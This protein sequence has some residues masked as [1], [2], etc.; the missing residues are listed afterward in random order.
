MNSILKAEGK[1]LY[2]S[3]TAVFGHL[4]Q[5]GVPSP[6]DRIRATRLAVGCI[7]WIEEV[8]KEQQMETGRNKWVGMSKLWTDKVWWGWVN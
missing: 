1:G 4:Q 5:G 7:D 3:R 6:S 2:D 8:S